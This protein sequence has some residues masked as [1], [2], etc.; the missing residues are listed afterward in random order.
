MI[1]EESV[2]RKDSGDQFARKPGARPVVLATR[3]GP[4]VLLFPRSA[5]VVGPFQHEPHD[6]WSTEPLCHI[7]ALGWVQ[8]HIAVTIRGADLDDSTLSC[9]EPADTGLLEAIRQ[10]VAP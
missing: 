8:T 2:L 3:P 7:N 4:N 10:A 1:A 9:F 6:H 5:S